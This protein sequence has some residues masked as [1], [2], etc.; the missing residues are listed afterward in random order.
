MLKETQD[1]RN[2]L[3]KMFVVAEGDGRADEVLEGFV[4]GTVAAMERAATI[5]KV[6]TPFR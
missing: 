1:R 6:A 5:R 4:N 2:V 3:G